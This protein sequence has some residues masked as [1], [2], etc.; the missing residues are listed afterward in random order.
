M[1]LAT[2][3]GWDKAVSEFNRLHKADPNDPNLF[4]L[5]RRMGAQRISHADLQV[6]AAQLSNNPGF[7]VYLNQANLERGFVDGLFSLLSA[8]GDTAPTMPQLME[9]K[10]SLS[11]YV[12]KSLSLRPL[13]EEQ[14]QKMKGMV[15]GREDYAQSQSLA[16]VH[17]NPANIFERMNF[18]F[19]ET[20]AEE[21]KKESKGT[22]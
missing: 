3:D 22:S 8:A 4:K 5:D 7:D 14:F 15:M 2:Q 18:R 21:T 17:L 19:A 9:F 12:I 6:L 13:Y 10:P 11:F 1:T 16:V 20:P